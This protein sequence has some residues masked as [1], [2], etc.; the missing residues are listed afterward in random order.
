[1]TIKKKTAKNA[2]KRAKAHPLSAHDPEQH[3]YILRCCDSDLRSHGG[4]QWPGRGLV[5]AS[6]WNWCRVRPGSPRMAMGR[7]GRVCVRIDARGP[8]VDLDRRPRRMKSEIVE[9]EA[10]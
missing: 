10:R 3:A 2:T 6:N 9:P 7:R 5:E 1:M 4:F 8:G